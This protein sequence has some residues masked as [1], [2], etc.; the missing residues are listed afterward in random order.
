MS[1]PHQERYVN[2]VLGNFVARNGES[3]RVGVTFAQHGDVHDRAFRAFQQIGNFRSGESVG[4]FAFDAMND[5]A[6]TNA[7]FRCGRT[8]HGREYDG[9]IFLR[10][11]GHADAVIF[12]ALIFTQQ[13]VLAR[14]E[15]RG[16]RIE[17]TQHAGNGAIVKAL[18]VS[19]GMA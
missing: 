15:K 18:S 4:E 7:G 11:D 2:R 1:G 13:R 9:V 3:E 19:T 10:T 8:G 14:I 16:V 12:A 6:G 17:H 5:V